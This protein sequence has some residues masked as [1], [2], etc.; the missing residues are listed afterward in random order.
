MQIAQTA[1]SNNQILFKVQS[2]GGG[3]GRK[4]REGRGDGGWGRREGGR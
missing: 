4:K 1:K 2:N 3:E